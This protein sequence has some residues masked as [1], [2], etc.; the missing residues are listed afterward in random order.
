MRKHDSMQTISAGATLSPWRI[1]RLWARIG[2]ESFG[3]GSATTL[4]IQRIFIDDLRLLTR[5]EFAQLWS[6]C[7]LAPGINL[8]A[9]CIL[10]GKR[11]GGRWGIGIALAGFLLPSGSITCLLAALYAS[12][13]RFAAVQAVVRGVVPAT[14]GL[15]LVVCI[16]F[17][18]PLFAGTINKRGIAFPRILTTVLLI[19]LAVFGVI[20]LNLSAILVVFGSAVIG[21]LWLAPSAPSADPAP[22]ETVL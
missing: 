6:L 17:L 9:I 16:N 22:Q 19:A 5:E 13:A 12:I 18:R 20:A 21:A 11:F 14:G 7:Q 4:L 3:G 1:F 15:M 2:L 8:V 10:L